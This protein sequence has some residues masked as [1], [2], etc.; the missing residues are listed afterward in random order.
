MIIGFEIVKIESW[1]FELSLRLPKYKNMI[2]YKNSLHRNYYTLNYIAESIGRC[3]DELLER[4]LFYDGRIDFSSQVIC[5][6][7]ENQA[8]KFIDEVLEPGLL[9]MKLAN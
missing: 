7:T 1:N 5:F 4:V 9:I 8:Q 3:F 6:R 2:I